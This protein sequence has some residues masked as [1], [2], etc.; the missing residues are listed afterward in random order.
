MPGGVSTPKG[1][2]SH[3]HIMAERVV[4]P[5][6][7][8]LIEELES[9]EKDPQ[10]GMRRRVHAVQTRHLSRMLAGCRSAVGLWLSGIVFL[11]RFQKG[12]EAM[13]CP[14]GV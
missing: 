4:I 5:R 6:N 12:K 14:G 10:G 8:K 2:A 13:P 7:F 3:I 11:S 1:I 9:A